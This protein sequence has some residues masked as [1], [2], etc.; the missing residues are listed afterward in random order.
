MTSWLSL[1]AAAALLVC[2]TAVSGVRSVAPTTARR[3]WLLSALILQATS[4]VADAPFTV[5]HVWPAPASVGAGWAGDVL[6]LAAVYCVMGV[7][8]SE[9]GIDQRR[10]RLL[11]HVWLLALAASV[12]AAHLVDLVDPRGDGTARPDAVFSYLTPYLAYLAIVVLAAATL[13]MPSTPWRTGYTLGAAANIGIVALGI[14]VGALGSAW[15]RAH[16]IAALRRPALLAEDLH[17]SVFLQVVGAGVA[18][19]AVA[20]PGALDLAR[21]RR[22]V[23]HLRRLEGLWFRIVRAVPAVMHHHSGSDHP[24]PEVQ[25]YRRVIGILDGWRYLYQL[26]P[27]RHLTDAATVHPRKFPS[28]AAIHADAAALLAALSEVERGHRH[29][30]ATRPVPVRLRNRSI[31]TLARW[32]VAIADAMDHTSDDDTTPRR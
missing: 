10:P 30:G 12:M 18:I 15:S 31:D 9:R 19:A 1:A 2:A 20:G 29:P 4:L 28:R 11:C 13:A 8:T 27:D 17:P 3:Q 14:C 7:V 16:T 22:R 25:L 23:R 24:D 32:L 21:R 26:V 5:R 6:S